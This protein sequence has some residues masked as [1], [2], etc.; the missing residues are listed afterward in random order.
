MKRTIFT[1]LFSRYLYLIILLA[2][3]IPLFAFNT[4]RDYHYNIQG[5]RLEKIAVSVRYSIYPYYTDNKLSSINDFV[6]DIAEDLELRITIINTDGLVVAD[7]ERDPETMENH[8]NRPEIIQ[9]LEEGKGESI[10]YSETVNREMMYF[11]LPLIEGDEVLTVIR[12][13][14]FHENIELLLADLRRDIAKSLMLILLVT[15]LVSWIFARSLSYPIRQL[16]EAQDKVASGDFNTRIFLKKDD[17]FKRLMDSFNSMANDLKILFHEVT[18]QKEDLNVILTSINEGLLV[19]DKEGRVI[20]YN[21]SFLE[22]FGCDNISN[23]HYWEISR[24]YVFIELLKNAE[25]EKRSLSTEIEF[26]N[27][28]LLCSITYLAVKEELIV[29]ISDISEIK[30]FDTMKREFVINASHELRTPLTA[31]KG[32]IE[33]MKEE[34]NGLN[35]QYIDI[36]NRHTDRLITLVEDILELSKLESRTGIIETTGIDIKNLLQNVIKLFEQK[37]KDKDFGVN[38]IFDD[39]PEKIEAD[40]FRLEQLFINLLDNAINYTEEGEINITVSRKGKNVVF[41]LQDTGVGIPEDHL[42]RVFERFYVVDKSR[43]RKLGGTGLGLSIVKHIVL[44]HHGQINIESEQNKGTTVR[45]ELPL[46]L[47]SIELTEN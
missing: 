10:R 46:E 32:Y 25:R 37:L 34:G 22:F 29:V 23:K 13:S 14:E 19:L 15:V 38:L 20:H 5:K 6:R 17:E 4:L 31:I 44:Q 35:N 24:N 11:A 42:P 12:I 8:A 33:T 36:I 39:G 9:A 16:A 21:N 27:R 7:S 2:V 26:N 28:D 40:A 45:I 47:R 18:K 3:F 1:K 30:K 41:F 43:S